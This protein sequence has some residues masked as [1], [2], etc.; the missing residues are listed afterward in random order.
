MTQ[1]GLKWILN[2]NFS[3]VKLFLFEP[4]PPQRWKASLIYYINFCL[5]T[6]QGGYSW[7][8]IN[9]ILKVVRWI[10]LNWSV[11]RNFPLVSSQGNK[12]GLTAACNCNKKKIFFFENH[13]LYTGCPK[14]S[15]PMYKMA[16]TPTKI[17]LGLKK[18]WVLKNS[19][20]YLSYEHWNFAI[21]TFG[22]WEKWVQ[23]LYLDL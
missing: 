12:D 9:S 11:F 4:P 1:N 15:D 5:V 23:N 22:T 10:E 2:I 19:G 18:R 8:Q 7:K 3:T 21:L 14:K 13:F 17:K 20:N 16:I 6:L